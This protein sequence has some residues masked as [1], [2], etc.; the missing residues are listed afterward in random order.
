LGDL[1]DDVMRHVE[2]CL[3]HGTP[4]TAVWIDREVEFS[5]YGHDSMT[6]SILWLGVYSF[7]GTK[8]ICLRPSKLCDARF[9][10]LLGHMRVS[11][12]CMIDSF[13]FWGNL[14]ASQ[15]EYAL[16]QDGSPWL[17][18][19]YIRRSLSWLARDQELARD[20]SWEM[21]LCERLLD[22]WIVY[23]RVSL[24]GGLPEVHG[25]G[26]IYECT[27]QGILFHI[28]LWDAGIGVLGST[29]FDGVEFRVEWFLGELT[30]DP[31]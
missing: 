23:L 30:E 14:R 8:I 29:G 31:L 28:L 22:G 24:V 12:T 10:A 11:E 9:G 16:W 13:H 4:Q 27:S 1:D 18:I 19:R 17:R 3:E 15:D 25:V 20:D 26:I 5:D 2:A 21:G 7:V 6:I